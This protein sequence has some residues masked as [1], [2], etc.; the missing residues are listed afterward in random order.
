[1]LREALGLK[2]FLRFRLWPNGGGVIGI[3]KIIETVKFSIFSMGGGFC[4]SKFLETPKFIVSP[5]NISHHIPITYSIVFYIPQI[6]S[7]IPP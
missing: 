6:V 7:R 2:Q 4:Q 5:H 3:S 1:L